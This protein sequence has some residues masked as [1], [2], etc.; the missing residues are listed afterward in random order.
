MGVKVICKCTRQFLG[1]L[2]ES[3]RER[4]YS[5]LTVKKKRKNHLLQLYKFHCYSILVGTQWVPLIIYGEKLN[6]PII[7]IL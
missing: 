7:L 5:D 2:C 4:N 1:K 3:T 6:G